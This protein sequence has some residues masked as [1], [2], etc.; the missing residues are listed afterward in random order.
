[1]FPADAN[2]ARIA[3]MP[4]PPAAQATLRAA[5]PDRATVAAGFV[6][7]LL[8]GPRRRGL[9]VAGPLREGR[10]AIVNDTTGDRLELHWDALAL[11]WLGLWLNRGHGGFHHVALEPAN[12]AP[13]SLADAVERWRQ[14]GTLA[15]G[16]TA[17]WAVEWR[18]S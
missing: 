7:G 16:A 12:G 15:P 5:A 14:F 4:P 6:T 17:H 10:A 9:D 11:P 13:D 3:T 2:R 8:A 1:M 18:V